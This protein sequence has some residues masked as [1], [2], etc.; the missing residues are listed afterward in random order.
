MIHHSQPL[1]VSIHITGEST[2]ACAVAPIAGFY[3]ALDC[4]KPVILHLAVFVNV[5]CIQH[6][7]C[8]QP[9]RCVM[10]IAAGAT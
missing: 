7:S 4:V 9:A 8:G 10:A 1:R 5:S 6:I 3:T 2:H